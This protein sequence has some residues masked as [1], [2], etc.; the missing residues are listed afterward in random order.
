MASG[1]RSSLLRAVPRAGLVP[2]AAF[3]VH[4]LRFLL[5]FGSGAGAELAETGH[6]YLHSVVPWIMLVV[7]LSVG[8]FL[9]ALSRAASG[10]RSTSS[11]QGLSFLSLWLACAV[12]LLAIYCTQEFLEGL[13]ATG[14]PAGIQGIFGLGGLWAIPSAVGVGLV[15]AAILHA[16]RW[17]LDEICR[18]HSCCRLRPPPPGPAV[19]TPRE[20]MLV[21]SSPLVRGWCDRGPPAARM[22]RA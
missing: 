21:A 9:F 7:G 5:A 19:A 6:S 20:L 16:A 12:C 10:R 3:A 11:T 17:T 2:V 13:F 22:T 8:A 15:L 1:S 4:Q 18:R 14:H